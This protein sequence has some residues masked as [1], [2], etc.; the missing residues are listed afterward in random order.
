M[1][2]QNLGDLIQ[3]L[4]SD[5]VPLLVQSSYGRWPRGQ[6][7][8]P[9][10]W[11]LPT[12][13][14]SLPYNVLPCPSGGYICPFSGIVSRKGVTSFSR[15]PFLIF[16]AIMAVRMDRKLT[17]KSSCAV[18]PLVA[19]TTYFTQS[20]RRVVSTGINF[21]F[22]FQCWW[23]FTHFLCKFKIDPALHLHQQK[24]NFCF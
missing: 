9:R 20:K 14:G 24:V 4:I 22:W 16:N 17:A 7:W 12:S 21:H 11:V 23:T 6:G 3:I 19:S 1:A 13:A 8:P 18:R 15:P 10:L 5:E 2:G